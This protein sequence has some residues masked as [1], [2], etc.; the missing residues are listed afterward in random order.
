MS[1][2]Q[3]EEGNLVLC[4]VTKIIGT[5]VFVKL[6][7]YPI[8]GAMTFPEIAPG[9]IRN[10][11]DYAF[12]GKK[13]ICK[14]LNIRSN[15]VELSLR[16]VK[17]NER[18]EFNEHYKKEKSFSAMIRTMLGE[19]GIEIISKIKETEDLVEFIE[20]SKETPSK[21]E[22]F[23]SKEQAQKIISTLGDK[24]IKE[25]EI[26]KKFS[27]SSKDP[28]GIVLVKATIKEAS[29]DIAKEVL[30]IS[31]TAAGKYRI[32]IKTKDPRVSDQQLRKMIENL[33]TISK[34]N[35]CEFGEEKD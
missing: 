5:S 28:K 18:N 32:V 4:T 30:E 35:G 29:K 12:P 9:R 11:R 24:K 10:I 26:T 21:L 34:K 33:E 7:D 27:L 14:I 15:H 22:K 2:A 19:K 3:L 23:L 17:V 13:I 20:S 1:K 16:R 25:K 8:E 6:D 31:Y